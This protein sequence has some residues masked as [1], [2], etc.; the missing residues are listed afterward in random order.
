MLIASFYIQL[1][2]DKK[3]I[4]KTCFVRPEVHKARAMKTS[5]N[6]LFII[7][8]FI[9]NCMKYE[10]LHDFS[11]WLETGSNTADMKRFLSYTCTEEEGNISPT[12]K[13]HN[14]VLLPHIFRQ[15]A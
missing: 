5:I 14:K 7:V 3:K 8:I 13:N 15:I 2:T 1:S 10:A 4:I 6:F 11:V 12:S 9:E